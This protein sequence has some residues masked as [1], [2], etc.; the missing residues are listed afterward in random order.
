VP[1]GVQQQLGARTRR[2]TSFQTEGT[3]DAPEDALTWR[4]ELD[5][6]DAT[7]RRYTLVFEPVEGRL[8]SVVRR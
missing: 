7:L 6:D 8:L 3:V 1:P 4:V 5:T 2:E